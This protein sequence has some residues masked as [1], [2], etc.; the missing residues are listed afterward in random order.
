L[1]KDLVRENNKMV[2]GILLAG[3]KSRRM[4]GGDKCMNLLNGKPIL[5]HI[6]EC[7]DPQVNQLVI[8]TNGDPK[9]FSSFG[10]QVILDDVEGYLGPLAGILSGMEWAKKNV[11]ECKWIATFATDTPFLP[12]NLVQRLIET[13]TY[14]SA[15]VTFASSSERRHPVFGLWPVSLSEDLRHALIYEGIRK[16]DHWAD[17]YNCAEVSFDEELVDP[18][19]N[20]NKPEDLVQ[21]EFLLSNK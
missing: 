1:K 11:L 5:E 13:A 2:A 21:A 19:F 10:L 15:D 7:V 14:Y 3:G 8:N 9:R 6:I 20:I 17:K 18:F 16:I 4:G 12:P